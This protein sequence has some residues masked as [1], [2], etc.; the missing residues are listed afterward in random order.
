M[1]DSGTKRV[2]FVAYYFPPRGG[3]GVQRSL[4]FVKY[5][6]RFGWEPTVLASAYERRSGAYD[7]TLLSEVPEGTEIVTVPSLERFFVNLSRWG[8]GRAAGFLFRPDTQVTWVRKAVATALRLNEEAHFDAVYTSV[9]PWSAGFVGLYLKERAGLPWVLDFRD[10]WTR[11]LHLSWPTRMHWERDRRLEGRFLAAADTSLVVT[12][13]MREEF[14]ADHPQLP[15]ERVKV[16]YNGYDEEDVAA[17]PAADDGK[18]TVVFTGKF[19]Y[20]YRS[21]DASAGARRPIRDFGTFARRDVSLDTHSPV[22]FLRGL[23]EFLRRFP[24]RRATT[25]VVFAGTVGDGNRAL[26]REL[27]L[28]DVVLCPGYLP[29]G[30]SVALVRSADAL[31]LPMFS[32]ANP[33]ER[34]AY[35]SGKVFEYMAA[36]KPILALAQE[37]DAKDLAVGSGLGVAVPPRDVDAIR[38]AIAR[39]YDDW[40]SGRRTLSPKE[41]FIRGFTRERLA[42][43]LAEVLDA[44]AAAGGA[45]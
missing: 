16:I 15:P 3:A 1:A 37:G 42:G 6:R 30:Q 40:S 8:L 28:T 25:R 11:S 32:T 10:P 2:L 12:P 43:Q 45:P 35:A 18:F 44:A 41:E 39:L 38:D 24:D 7:E 29:H 36:G 26:A 33:S 31:L 27:G 34:I 9:Q 5:L 23:A 4:K 13:T 21:A 14:L 20:D 17:A 22:Y 19:Q